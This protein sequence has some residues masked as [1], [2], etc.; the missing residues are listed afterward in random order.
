MVLIV[1]F[2]FV[3]LL[4]ENLFKTKLSFI[5]NNDYYCILN[6]IKKYTIW[7]F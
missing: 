7:K 5:K 4:S 3:V 2:L 1:R 6:L